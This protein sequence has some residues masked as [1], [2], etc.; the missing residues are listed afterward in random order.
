M[1]EITYDYTSIYSPRGGDKVYTTFKNNMVGWYN[2]KPIGYGPVGPSYPFSLDDIPL[3][4][5][6]LTEQ[7]GTT[8]TLHISPCCTY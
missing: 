3:I 4:M 5:Q 8:P 1:F 6:I 7:L 2:G